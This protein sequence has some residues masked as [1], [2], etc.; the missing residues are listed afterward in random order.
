M[1]VCVFAAL[2]RKYSLRDSKI[3]E[4]KIRI[5]PSAIVVGNCFGNRN[6]DHIYTGNVVSVPVK[7]NAIINSSKDKVK[8]SNK[9]AII[10]GYTRGRITRRNV[11]IGVSPRSRDASSKLISRLL[12]AEFMIS[13][14][15]GI[16]SSVWPKTTLQR[17]S[18]NPS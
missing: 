5:V 14:E 12:K 11:P 17:L 10:P 13:I 2:L 7:K 6:N 1:E 18:G 9:L 16:I 8:P 3:N 4:T 15:K